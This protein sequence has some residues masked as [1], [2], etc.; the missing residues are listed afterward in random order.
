[1]SDE[2]VSG[3]DDRTVQVQPEMPHC[4]ESGGQEHRTAK[5]GTIGL[6]DTPA[7]D[8]RRKRVYDP[9]G[10]THRC[11]G[12]E[13]GSDPHVIEGIGGMRGW[14][15]PDREMVSEDE[16]QERDGGSARGTGAVDG[17][18]TDIRCE[19]PD[20]DE[21]RECSPESGRRVMGKIGA[22]KPRAEHDRNDQCCE[23]EPHRPEAQRGLS[24]SSEPSPIAFDL[25]LQ[26]TEVEFGAVGGRGC[27]QLI[28]ARCQV[29]LSLEQRSAY[30]AG[31]E[32]ILRFGR[33]VPLFG[34]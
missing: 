34:L 11:D 1:M 22:E 33:K 21:S 2:S 8:A 7:D 18:E 17:L 6:L 31:I 24:Q 12:K 4:A 30:I 26:V 3:P 27:L 32:M 28:E 15:E 10:Q 23:R 9:I 16:E 29:G 14:Q 25:V 19:N 13:I 5:E 20:A